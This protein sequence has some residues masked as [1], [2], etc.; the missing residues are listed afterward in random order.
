[1]TFL[2]APWILRNFKHLVDEKMFR[3][4]SSLSTRIFPDRFKISELTPIHKSGSR[5]DVGN[6]RGVAILPTIGKL[7]EAIVC[8]RLTAD[9]SGAISRA[10]HGFRKGRSTSTNLMEFVNYALNLI[11]SGFQVDATYTDISKLK[12]L[13]VHH[14]LLDWIQSYLDNRLQ[15]VIVLGWKSDNFKVPSGLP[16]GSHLGP[17]FSS[18]S[19][20]MPLKYVY[21]PITW[22]IC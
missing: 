15:C 22:S 5:N 21:L 14:C 4:H 20:T 6:Y 8:V 17:L 2:R 16:Q 19:S 3:E 18:S 10:Q 9:L 7:F 1:M 12:E 13:G 11:E